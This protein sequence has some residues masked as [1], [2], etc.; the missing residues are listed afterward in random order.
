MTRKSLYRLICQNNTETLDMVSVYFDKMIFKFTNTIFI[1][2]S[3]NEFLVIRLRNRDYRLL[4]LV[5]DRD[6]DGT[7]YHA[8]KYN[9]LPKNDYKVHTLNQNHIS[10]L[11]EHLRRAE[12]YDD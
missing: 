12:R 10:D 7:F 5:I 11:L 4:E 9:Y 8:W 1:D 2:S 6:C 3:G